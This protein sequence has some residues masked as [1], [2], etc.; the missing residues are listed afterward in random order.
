VIY[1]E[2]EVDEDLRIGNKYNI[3]IIALDKQTE[4]KKAVN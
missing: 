1:V 4:S 3:Q 2:I